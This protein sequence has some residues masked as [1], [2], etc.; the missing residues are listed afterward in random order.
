MKN[1]LI[2]SSVALFVMGL[3]GNA[4]AFN[5]GDAAKMVKEYSK[6]VACQAEDSKYQAAKVVGSADASGMGDRFVVYWEGDV[7]CMGGRGTV[8][9]Q[10]TVVEIAAFDTPVVLPDYK[11]PELDLAW[12][13]KF[14]AKNGKVFI[15][16]VAY[17]PKDPQNAP[18]KKVKYPLKL[19]PEGFVKQ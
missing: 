10:L 16:G 14:S 9:P 6:L 18:S 17:G 4:A 11:M 2:V 15:Q 12:V 13:T 5:E 3:A 19:G 1:M 8:S 7:G